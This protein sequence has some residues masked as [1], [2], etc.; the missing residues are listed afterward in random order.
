MSFNLNEFINLSVVVLFFL[1]LCFSLMAE[2]RATFQF[3][4]CRIHF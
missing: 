1:M 4:H 3:T 2:L